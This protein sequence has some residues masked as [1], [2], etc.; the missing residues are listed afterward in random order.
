MPILQYI[1]E[2]ERSWKLTKY[3]ER[4]TTICKIWSVKVKWHCSLFLYHC[5]LS[6]YWFESW[7]HTLIRMVRKVCTCFFWYVTS[8]S[9]CTGGSTYQLS[10][11]RSI[12]P[13]RGHT[14][15]GREQES[16][17]LH[18]WDRLQNDGQNWC[19]ES[20][21]AATRLLWATTLDS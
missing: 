10:R 17:V 1:I 6:E 9:Y 11:S 16:V 21:S 12:F 5:Y 7:R 18:S 8:W 14:I 19:H 4:A 13:L 2:G 20:W 15:V 3:V